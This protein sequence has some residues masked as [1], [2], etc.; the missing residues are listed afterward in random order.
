MPLEIQ[1]LQTPESAKTLGHIIPTGTRSNPPTGY[2]GIIIRDGQIDIKTSDGSIF[3]A[4]DY[5]NP[6]APFDDAPV[7]GK[8]AYWGSILTGI[9]GGIALVAG[10]II[11]GAA[12]YKN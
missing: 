1:I 4:T 8:L 9:L 7:S 12:I 10:A 11:F 5:G 6:Y 2:A 3:H